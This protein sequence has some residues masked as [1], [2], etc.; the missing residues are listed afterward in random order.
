MNYFV[1]SK[2]SVGI[3]AENNA[4]YIS[5]GINLNISLI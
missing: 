1:I 5:P 4:I 2:I 3:V